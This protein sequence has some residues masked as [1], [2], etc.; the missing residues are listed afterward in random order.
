[1]ALVLE[2]FLKEENIGFRYE[3][4]ERALWRVS[5]VEGQGD[6][7]FFVVVAAVGMRKQPR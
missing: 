4:K 7:R 2:G 1:M 5:A 6:L 3:N